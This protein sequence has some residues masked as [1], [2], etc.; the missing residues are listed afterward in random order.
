MSNPL[1][2]P[3]VE[4]PKDPWS[5]V[6]IAEDIELIGH[7]I[8]NGSWID[9]SL[10]V[11]GASLDALA[12]IDDPIGVLLQYGVA[13]IIE[14]VKPL[15][16]ALDW[17]AGDPAQ[18]AANAQTWRNIAQDLQRQGEDLARAVTF[19][20][21]EWNGDAAGQYRDW[22]RQQQQAITALGK[23]GQTMALITEGAGFLIAAVRLLVRD[24]IATLVSRLIVYAAEEAASF[25]FATPLV[26]EQVTTLVASWTAKIARWLKSLLHSLR[27]L[28]PIIRRIGGLIEEIKN[29]L[30][31]LR[32]GAEESGFLNRVRKRGAGPIQLFNME[33]VRAIAAKYGIDIA[34]LN[35]T[36]GS[37]SIRGVCGETRPDG[38]IV[39][40][41][42]GFR[43][44]EDLARTLEHE[45]FHHDE[46]AAGRPYPRTAAEF[47]QWEDRAYAHEE[48]WWNNH[49]VRPEP[50]TR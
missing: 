18:I 30:N 3:R 12:L 26:A 41:P 42:T 38:S 49:N 44:E 7:G 11:I 31:R 24:A 32:R 1:L 14:H 8:E 2:A 9:G 22:S 39:L 33:S 13:W 37:K 25:L 27:N 45:R 36:L 21:S 46:I 50:R 6:W 15:S 4:A 34:D 35:I 47:D 19:D 29:I 10:G 48:Q 16:Q 43:S 23:A 17:L 40:Y 28:L 5:G 20:L